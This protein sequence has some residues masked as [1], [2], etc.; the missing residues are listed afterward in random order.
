MI[1]ASFFFV[2]AGTNLKSV[3]SA[4][5][6]A[7]AHLQFRS[8]GIARTASRN[9]RCA[10]SAFRLNVSMILIGHDMNDTELRAAIGCE[11]SGPRE[12]GQVVRVHIDGTKDI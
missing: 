11:L 7:T 6:S 12:R 10:F 4:C 9:T 3:I 8:A 1:A 5:R 2:P